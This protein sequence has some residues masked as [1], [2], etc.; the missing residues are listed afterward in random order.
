MGANS[1]YFTVMYEGL[2]M[3]QGPTTNNEF[4]H[5]VA[6]SEFTIG[7]VRTHDGS[8]VLSAGEYKVGTNGTWKVFPS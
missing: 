6:T 4:T 1:E 8:T 7:Y 3:P 2:P 5:G